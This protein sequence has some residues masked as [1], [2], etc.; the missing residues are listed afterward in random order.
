LHESIES[1]TWGKNCRHARL[2]DSLRIIYLYE[3]KKKLNFETIVTH[4][5][6]D[7]I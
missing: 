7:K 2:T 5:E 3:P 6:L 4:N 1:E